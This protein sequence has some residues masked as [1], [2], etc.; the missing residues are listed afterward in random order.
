MSP[1]WG[2]WKEFLYQTGCCRA[3]VPIPTFDAALLKW[4]HLIPGSKHLC[5]WYAHQLPVVPS[6]E[7]VQRLTQI[8]SVFIDLPVYKW[9]AVAK[10]LE[11]KSTLV[12]NRSEE[13]TSELQSQFHLVCRLL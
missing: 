9:T 3:C 1:C 7:V 12:L 2:Q 13:H 10:D 8:V 11:M 4:Y 5:H 6:S